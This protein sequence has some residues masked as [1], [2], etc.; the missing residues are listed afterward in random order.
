MESKSPTKSVL[1]SGA[2]GANGGYR[3]GAGRPLEWV[4]RKCQT[5][6]DKNKLLDFLVE[7]SAGKCAQADIKDRLR[8]TEMLM[9]RA[10]G[11]PGQ[12]VDV[13]GTLQTETPDQVAAREARIAAYIAAAGAVR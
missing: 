8:A 7:V 12:S 1:K 3:P 4:K 2:R 5:L 10:W 13:T 6:V 11:R 9:D